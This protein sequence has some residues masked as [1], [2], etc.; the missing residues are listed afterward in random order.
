MATGRARFD[1][2]RAQLSELRRHY[3]VRNTIAG[4][5]EML[6]ENVTRAGLVVFLLLLLLGMFGPMITPHGIEDLQYTEDGDLARLEPP[7]AEYPLGTTSQGYDVLSRLIYGARPTMYAA[8]V[9]GMI[10]VVLGSTIG[11]TAGYV[12]GNVELVLMRLNDFMYGVPLIPFAIVLLA[13]FG[14]SFTASILVI[15]LIYWRVSSRVL[16]SQVLQIKERPYIESAKA[17]G[18]SRTRIIFKHILPNIANMIALWFALSAGYVVLYQAG[19]AFLGVVDPFIPSWGVMIRN[20]Y[21][22]GFVY[23]AWWWSIPPGLM[24][25]ATVLSTFLIGRGYENV[26]QSGGGM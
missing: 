17:V 2:V 25:S 23:D 14:A 19:L 15:A 6:S 7:S 11:I 24:I 16:R 1:E 10:A 5:K 20:A 12:G 22:R 13:F 18:A 3:I 9:G 21:A 8:L 26:S 4:L